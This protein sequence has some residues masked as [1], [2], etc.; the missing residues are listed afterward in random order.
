MTNFEQ[1]C[2]V[3]YLLKIILQEDGDPVVIESAKDDAG[4]GM[5]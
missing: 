2:K 3:L 5:C 4:P 1:L